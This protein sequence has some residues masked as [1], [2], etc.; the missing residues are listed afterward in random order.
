[1]IIELAPR[2]GYGADMS[3]KDDSVRGGV[4]DAEVGRERNG[5]EGNRGF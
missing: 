1:M 2:A 5:A 4:D 3:I